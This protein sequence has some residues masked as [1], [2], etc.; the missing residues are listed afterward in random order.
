MVSGVGEALNRS[1]LEVADRR[2]ARTVDL[3]SRPSSVR[4]R[5]GCTNGWASWMRDTNVYRYAGD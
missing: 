5:T 2:G 3:T 1:A 4:R